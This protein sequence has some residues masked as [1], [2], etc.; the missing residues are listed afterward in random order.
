MGHK[1]VMQH[2]RAASPRTHNPPV[3][4]AHKGRVG[5]ALDHVVHAQKVGLER[6]RLEG[7]GGEGV[8]GAAKP[9][10]GGVDA[11]ARFVSDRRK[12]KWMEMEWMDDNEARRLSTRCTTSL[13]RF[14]PPP[15]RTMMPLGALG[16]CSC[17]ISRRNRF[18]ASILVDGGS[19]EPHNS[20]AA[21]AGPV[22]VRG[23]RA[24]PRG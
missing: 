14:T 12:V 18:C 2:A 11:I 3:R 20:F 9:R 8:R 15:P 5:R 22:G 13:V 6:A 1:D 4:P 7:G 24:P 16:D 19:R 10:R 17:A 23:A 21:V